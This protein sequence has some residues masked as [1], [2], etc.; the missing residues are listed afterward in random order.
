MKLTTH[1]A[2]LTFAAL[3]IPIQAAHAASISYIVSQDTPTGL[4][5]TINHPGSTFGSSTFKL[6]PSLKNWAVTG[7]LTDFNAG[8]FSAGLDSVT[9]TGMTVNQTVLP[10]PVFTVPTLGAGP[11]PAF[12]KGTYA[13]AP[14]YEAS[15]KNSAGGIDYVKVAGTYSS[16]PTILGGQDINAYNIAVVGDHTVPAAPPPAFGGAAALGGNNTP[17]M[18]TLAALYDSTTNLLL[19]DVAVMLLPAGDSITDIQITS[20]DPSFTTLSLGTSGLMSDGVP[21]DFSLGADVFIP[22]A[23]LADIEAGNSFVN[24]LTSS[25]PTGEIGGAIQVSQISTVPEP[26]SFLLS[27]SGLVAGLAW[28]RVTSSQS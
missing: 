22:S 16:S 18:G 20:S 2:V 10:G 12:P 24:V 14:P 7:T 4:I 5:L 1:V 6:A 3:A 27:L 28:W 25:A 13:F 11:G 17:A 15:A 8:L 26:S 21:G 23:D 19:M 9:L